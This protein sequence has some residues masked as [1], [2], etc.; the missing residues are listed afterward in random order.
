MPK[1]IRFLA[2]KG[3]IEP[4]AGF[5]DLG[6]WVDI[7]ATFGKR[8]PSGVTMLTHP[9]HPEGK[10]TWVL[11]RAGSMQNAAFPG[12]E[13]LTLSKE[14]PLELRYRLVIHR[15]PATTAQLRAWQA[16]FVRP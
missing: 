9:H 4:E 5:M 12:S 10:Q 8:N 13:P 16:D 7:S 11:R 1:D 2:E 15:G 14:Q 6:P 3:E